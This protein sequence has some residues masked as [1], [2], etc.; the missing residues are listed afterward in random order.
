MNIKLAHQE[1]IRHI[2]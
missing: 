1:R 2:M